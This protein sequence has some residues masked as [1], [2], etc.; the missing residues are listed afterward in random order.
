ME[1]SKMKTWQ[2]VGLGVL[3]VGVTA[4]AIYFGYK[5]FKKKMVAKD[6]AKAAAVKAE[7]KA[8]VKK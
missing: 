1:G 3:T 5:A 7:V 8:E 4:T 6:A 2:K